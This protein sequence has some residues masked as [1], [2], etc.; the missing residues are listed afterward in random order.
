MHLQPGN[1]PASDLTGAGASR[2]VTIVII[3]SE[4]TG[5][6]PRTVAGALSQSYSPVQVIVIDARER[7]IPR[8]NSEGTPF[9]ELPELLS[10]MSDG[11]E[12]YQQTNGG[13]ACARNLGLRKARGE[14][15]LFVSHDQS[16]E[17]DAVRRLIDVGDEANRLEVRGQRQPA[18][19]VTDRKASGRIDGTTAEAMVRSAPD[20]NTVGFVV[21]SNRNPHQVTRLLNRLGS[22]F[23]NPPVACHH[24]FGQSDLDTRQFPPS[25]RFVQD[26][27]AT[28]RA[29]FSLV[30]ATLAALRLLYDGGDGPDWFVVLSG[31][32]YP[33]KPASRILEDLNASPCDALIHHEPIH[34]AGWQRPW[35]RECA[36]RYLRFQT[37]VPHITRRGRLTKR[38]IHLP[39]AWCRPFVPFSNAFLCY[40]G[41]QWFSARRK[42]AQYILKAHS[43]QA[44]LLRH[45]S[46]CH[47]PDESYFQ[48]M[49]ANESAFEL[50]QDC[51][52]YIDWTGGGNSPKLLGME[53]L[54]SLLASSAHFARKFDVNHDSR[55][56]DVLDDVVTE[57]SSALHDAHRISSSSLAGA[58]AAGL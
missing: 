8:S 35:Q 56:L 18:L 21:L 27:I 55:V 47:V 51:K 58:V 42:C 45:Y 50:S 46:R 32:D 24:D 54:P 36:D 28:R 48:S 20:Q 44:R 17:P 22:M 9:I 3:V 12:F 23:E 1:L 7:A 40:A 37:T 13:I 16:L 33:I 4:C 30:A 49:L 43:M 15:V 31:A 39:F 2:L 41:S 11:I 25:V 14:S 10:G 19:S 6:L 29:D 57:S 26:H 38:R 5:A 52:R 53:D 34:A